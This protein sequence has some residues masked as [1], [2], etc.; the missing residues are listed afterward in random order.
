M[1][2]LLCNIK[3]CVVTAHHP[4]MWVCNKTCVF[5]KLLCEIALVS[6]WQSLQPAGLSAV[7]KTLHHSINYKKK[8]SWAALSSLRGGKVGYTFEIINIVFHFCLLQSLTKASEMLQGK[9]V[10]IYSEVPLSSMRRTPMYAYIW[11]YHQDTKLANI[12]LYKY[13]PNINRV[14]GWYLALVIFKADPLKWMYI[15]QTQNK[16]IRINGLWFQ[17]I[18]SGFD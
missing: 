10:P 1:C 14:I 15:S 17:W 4:I 16:L 11:C 6:I 9:P 7:C 8:L 13:S 2:V 18:Y 5:S 12:Y 3:G